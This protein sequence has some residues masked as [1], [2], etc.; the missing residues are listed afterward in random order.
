MADENQYFKLFKELCAEKMWT[1]I[2][3][4]A[5]ER[6]IG[7]DLERPSQSEHSCLNDSLYLQLVMFYDVA[8]I[9]LSYE[10]IFSL[11]KEQYNC[12]QELVASLMNEL[13]VFLT[14][15]IW[16][17]ELFKKMTEDTWNDL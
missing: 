9:R 13:E 5:R 7:C 12:K 10:S 3:S 14:T 1:D 2:S 4:I 17:K 8:F 6:C 15:D 11:L 16:K